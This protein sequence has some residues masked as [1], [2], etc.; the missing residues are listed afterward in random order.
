MAVVY[1]IQNRM[2][3]KTYV[4]SALNFGHRKKQHIRDLNRGNHHSIPLQRAWDK[5]GEEAFEWKV[6]EYV[7]DEDKL[8]ER[9]Q[10]YLDLLKP[11]GG[12]GYNVCKIAGSVRGLKMGRE[13]KEKLRVLAKTRMSDP[14]VR[15][16]MNE[17]R[18]TQAANMT[19]EDRERL[20]RRMKQS[21]EEHRPTKLKAIKE[22]SKGWRLWYD[23][24][25]EEERASFHEKRVAKMKATYAAG[26][27]KSQNRNKE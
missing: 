18:R 21:A 26:K 8:I 11:F 10:H 25:S 7:E 5:Y 17:R 3:G 20:R 2:T 16:D 19:E 6:L 4:G 9:E 13:H 23:S 14:E 1:W 12:N 27:A 24:L 22:A 15:K